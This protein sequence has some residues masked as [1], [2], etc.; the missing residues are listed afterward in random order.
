MTQLRVPAVPGLPSGDSS[1][2]T[3]DI[4]GVKLPQLDVLRG[5]CALLVVFYHVMFLHP[6]RDL[7]LFR[8]AS[9]FVD[10]FF[11]LSGFIM[12]HN[13][14]SLP[15]WSDFR[16]FIGLRLFRTYPL[17]LAMLLVFLAY[18]TAQYVLV[19]LYHLPTTTPPFSDSNT[20]TFALNLFLL[21]GVGLAPLSFNTP[22]WSISTEF[23]AYVLFGVSVMALPGKRS[24]LAL[25]F[26]GIALASLALLA[27][28]PEPGLTIRPEMF[29]PRCLFGFFLGAALRIGIDRADHVR[30]TIAEAQLGTLAQ[31]LA[32]ALAVGLVSIVTVSTRELE[33]FTPF[34]FALLIASFVFWPET[35]LIQW[36]N[37]NSALLWLGKV[38]YSVY[39]VHQIVLQVI[40]A[41]MKLILHAP[42][43]APDH[44]LLIGYGHGALA[45]AFTLTVLLVTAGLSHRFIEEPARRFGRAWLR[46]R[47]APAVD[48]SL[49]APAATAPGS[50]DA[51][52]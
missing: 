4:A 47:R 17:H 6:G 7:N 48:A 10:F 34:A 46:D 13:Y 49:A 2:T 9:L 8:N 26:V 39:M 41:F 45:L 25:L 50:I 20:Y 19:E 22:S 35:A 36:I 18:E 5:C 21:N 44:V 30:V 40:E 23:W 12:L 3:F 27:T 16:Q 33:L 14:G 32:I 37:G 31:T 52:L 11:V 28:R 29:L 24:K 43:R 51:T 1:R 42:A 38:S 15:R